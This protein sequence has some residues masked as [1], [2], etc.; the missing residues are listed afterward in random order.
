[1][2]KILMWSVIPPF[3]EYSVKRILSDNLI[4][5]NTGNLLFHSSV[6]RALMT[7]GEVEYETVFGGVA[8]HLDEAA[9]R[10]NEECESFV[11]PLANAFRG[12]YMAKLSTLTELIKRLKIPCVVVGVGIQASKPENLTQ[13]FAFDD[14]VRDFVGAVLDKSALLGVRGE[15]TSKYLQHLGFSPERHFT[16]I[17]CPS[18]YMYGSALPETRVNP[19]TAQSRVC[20]NGKM[21][22]VKEIHALMQSGCA[23]LPNYWYIP[24]RIEEIWMM[25]AGIPIPRRNKKKRPEYIP[26]VRSNPLLRRQRSVAFMNV[27][28]WME[29]MKDMDLSYGCNIHGNIAAYLAGVPGLVVAKDL[30]VGELTDYFEIPI[31]SR[32]EIEAKASIID[33]YERADFSRVRANHG[34]RFA[35]YLDFLNANGLDHIFKESGSVENA[36]YDIRM[37]QTKLA[38]AVYP[39]VPLTP[40]Q[41][42]D[43]VPIYHRAVRHYWKKY[44]NKFKARYLRRK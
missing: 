7:S 1:M 9:A 24:Q 28:S 33:A 21:D 23:E 3:N 8:D 36:P 25:Y 38:P 6:A 41:C 35:H 2:R 43:S 20:V 22:S 31:V 5:S 4:G 27:P 11:I 32:A 16:P 37:A 12:D 19:L 17:G 10:I 14:K 34:K 44:K 30:R 13:G 39:R 42:V 15:M 29:F 40:A 26:V 18:M